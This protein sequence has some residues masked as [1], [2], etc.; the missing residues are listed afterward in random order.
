[1]ASRG[2]VKSAAAAAAVV[3]S[4]GDGVHDGDQKPHS[5][6]STTTT[7]S[8]HEH[9]RDT[10]TA[11]RALVEE[12]RSQLAATQKQLQTVMDHTDATEHNVVRV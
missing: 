5:L 1:M 8:E 11:L 4:C 3:V 10:I 12:A 2:V 7:T 6:S 9:S